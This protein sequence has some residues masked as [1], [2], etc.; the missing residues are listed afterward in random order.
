MPTN[1]VRSGEE[2]YWEEAKKLVEEQYGSV[3]DHWGA[4]M[5]IFK[6]KVGDHGNHSGP[7]RK[8]HRKRKK[9]SR[10]VTIAS[11]VASRFTESL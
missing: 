11:R 8:K 6:N 9:S 4:V 10:T 3:E 5:T 2:K 1:V 7:K